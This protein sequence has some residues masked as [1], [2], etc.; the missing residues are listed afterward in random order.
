LATSTLIS[1]FWSTFFSADFC[2]KAYTGATGAAT[3]AAG[4]T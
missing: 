2:I 4:A 1:V 3:G